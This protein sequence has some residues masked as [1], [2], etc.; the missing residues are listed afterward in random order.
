MAN[1]LEAFK[2]VQIGE[3][4]D[5][6]LLVPLMK[7]FST[8]EENIF[9]VQKINRNFYYGNQ[10]I[11]IVELI[12]NIRTK[13]FMRYPKKEAEE[14]PEFYI[15]DLATYFDTTPSDILKSL[16]SE[17]IASYKEAISVDFAYDDKQRKQIGL[18]K[19]GLTKCRKNKK[20]T[21][22]MTF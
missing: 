10:K 18:K 13:G 11:F 12:L 17:E 22:L 2:S 7:W 16:G 6:N 3:I 1:L 21:T 8:K 5:S 9:G 20:Q 4:V 14:Y 19:R 15:E